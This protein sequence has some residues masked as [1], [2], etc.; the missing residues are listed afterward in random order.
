MAR[1]SFESCGWVHHILW[2]PPTIHKEPIFR[3]A[4][5]L[6]DGAF[7]RADPI[8]DCVSDSFFHAPNFRSEL[9]SGAADICYFIEYFGF[10]CCSSLDLSIHRP[11][12]P[13]YFAR[14]HNS[15]L[16]R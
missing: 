15:A 14:F 6:F 10:H 9:S 7:R 2:P 1:P 13:D 16:I 12:T 11:K 5:A 3:R 8:F 4:A